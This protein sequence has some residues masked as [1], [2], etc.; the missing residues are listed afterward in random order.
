L[1][2]IPSNLSSTA[3]VAVGARSSYFASDA[4]YEALAHRIGAALRKGSHP[5]VLV[6]GDP[7]ANPRV[8]SEALGNVAGPRYAVIIIPCGP[9]LTRKDLERTASIRAGPGASTDAATPEF[10]VPAL[11]LFVFDDFDRLSDKQIEDVYEGTVHR[12]QM[13]AAAVL[14]APLD[15]VVR[16]ERPALHF[17]KDRIA[18][19]FRFQ[20]VGDEEAIAFL[21][22]QLLSQ[23]DRRIEARGFR[24]GILVGV[25][26]G[27]VAIV[28][29]IGA[30][31]LHPTAEKIREAPA[32]TGRS[33]SVSEEASI[34]RPAEEAATSVVTA[35]AAPKTETATVFA[36]APPP[37]SAPPLHPTEVESVPPFAPPAMAYSAAGPR[38]SA[39]E[40]T[41]LLGRGDAFL[42]S[43]DIT[44]A[45]LFYERAADA[46]SGL[47]ALQLGATFDPV[48][49]GRAGVRGVT[50][51]PAQA[52]SWYRR[53]R[54]LGVGEAEQRI[55]GLETRRLGSVPLK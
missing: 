18:A 3:L 48:T 36:A 32:S 9:E 29:S 1:I 19:Q 8:L 12:D 17:L 20:E 51:D 31:I 30:F 46:G 55:K 42:S 27:G 38:P 4:H 49:L 54:E 15:F 13:P 25:A 11:P 16:L 2:Q 43:G 34:L 6:T 33:G 45:R 40:I 23:R 5:F 24:R 35:Q 52:L 26:V 50:A 7:P 44:S 22:N 28:A 37:L 53:A 47:A 14:L 39:A 10:S 41:A 21:H